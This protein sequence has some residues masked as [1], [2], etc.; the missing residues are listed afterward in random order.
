VA[1]QHRR[2][3]DDCSSSSEDN[4]KTTTLAIKVSLSPST[5]CPFQLIYALDLINIVAIQLLQ[6]QEEERKHC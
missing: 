2:L 4:R 5:L 1:L 6:W 3:Q